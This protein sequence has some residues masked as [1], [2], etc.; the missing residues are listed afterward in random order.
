MLKCADI[1]LLD[2]MQNT[3]PLLD[4]WIQENNDLVT[5]WMKQKDLKS[6]HRDERLY[7]IRRI[8][9]EFGKLLTKI[10][11]APHVTDLTEL[12]LTALY[13]T[14]V[15]SIVLSDFSEVEVLITNTINKIFRVKN[16]ISGSSDHFLFWREVAEQ[17]KTHSNLT[18]CIGKLFCLQ[19]AI[20]LATQKYH[21][22]REVE[23]EL[24]LFDKISTEI[25]RKGKLR[26]SL[27]LVL[28]PKELFELLHICTLIE[29]GAERLADGHYSETL[30][31]MKKA[32]SLPAPRALVACTYL[33]SG[34]CFVQMKRPQMAL[35]CFQKALDTDCHCVSALYQSMLIYRQL[36]NKEAEI[37][38]LELLHSGLNATH[39]S[40]LDKAGDHI[41][42]FSLLLVSPSLRNLMIVPSAPTLL[43]S[44]ASRC[45][46]H[47][48]V[49]Q[50]VE[51]YLDLLAS[52]HTD[53]H[54]L[55]SS[56]AVP[57]FPQLAE[58]YLEAAAALLMAHRPVDCIALCDEVLG[59]TLDLLPQRLVL[60][61][62]DLERETVLLCTSWNPQVNP[63]KGAMVL[64]VGAAHLLQGHCQIHLKDWKQAI[65][66][67]SRCIEFLVKVQLKD[68]GCQP[69]IPTSNMG[70]NESKLS[71]LQRLKA[72]SFAGRGI[73]FAQTDKLKEALRDLHFSLHAFPECG[74]AGR[75][76][77]EVL[78]RLNRR[79][80]A[81]C[82]W[83]I[84]LDI[85]KDSAKHVCVYLMEPP[86]E[87]LMNPSELQKKMKD[88]GFDEDDKMSPYP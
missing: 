81:A 3:T 34:S 36:G 38:V 41:L 76:C 59:A 9:L 54:A 5:K 35:V 56:V 83:K 10:Q 61:E 86:T 73:C 48:R 47:G 65:T 80:E 72:F 69:L 32:T 37:K 43:H 84:S 75:W 50:G 40:E 29:Q 49:S 77:G 87:T 67:Y 68:N 4:K 45:V 33:L 52:L 16:C 21:V 18:F 14:G 46:L 55:C 51:H 70:N 31:D 15:F 58:L 1:H 85:T 79:H 19:W 44:L 22:I 88:L 30:S 27:L 7:S 78:W 11:G 74:F 39:T 23:K 57:A 12:A 8:S 63:E 13:N 25:D 42:P 53:H 82:Y 17:M 62:S 20:W 24:S 60:E 71:I 66:H 6:P 26:E 28:E 2:K 64:W